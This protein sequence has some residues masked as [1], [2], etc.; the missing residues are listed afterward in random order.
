MELLD[1]GCGPGTM[2]LDLAA[3]VAPGR[4]IGVENV[5]A[6]LVA[7]RE[8]AAA[9]GDETTTFGVGDAL[10]LPFPDDSFDVVHAHQVLQH[11]T[12]PVTALREMRRVCR[13]GGW[14]AARDADYAAMSWYPG[15]A[16]ASV[17][18]H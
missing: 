2:T 17:V 15:A 18:R 6:P 10:A 11:L 4:V 13:P 3:F 8:A 16:P 9:R 12:D 14:V 5:E 7:A 1:V